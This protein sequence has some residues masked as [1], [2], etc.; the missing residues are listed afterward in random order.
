MTRS[1][2]VSDTDNNSRDGAAA[3][4]A[5]AP[6]TGA[7][8]DGPA[9][10]TSNLTLQVDRYEIFRDVSIQ[11]S[12]GE[13]VGLIGPIGSGK[14]ALLKTLATLTRPTRGGGAVAGQDL[15]SQ[16]DAIRPRVGYM[17][18]V[19]GAYDDLR[20]WEY[21]DF[22]ARA[23]RVEPRHIRSRIDRLLAEAELT[24]QREAFVETLGRE[25]K[26]R[27]GL[28]KTLLH[29]PRLLILDSP[30][31]GLPLAARR[32]L[33]ELIDRLLAPDRTLLL[34]TNIL[35]DLVGLC[36][37]AYVIA[38]GRIVLEGPMADVLRRLAPARAFEVRIGAETDSPERR[39]RLAEQAR[40]TLR[41][42]PGVDQAQ[43]LADHVV[44]STREPLEDP[45]P[46]LAALRAREIPVGGWREREIDLSV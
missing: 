29:E 6:G 9:I 35:S 39:A 20:V 46:W 36:S 45:A 22:F 42:A 10:V 34:G 12:S 37:R 25:E 4:A 2:S 24:D 5:P 16:A 30:A 43:S 19:L 33:R 11:V 32:R 18:D 28:I 15:L 40:E 17:P 23:G 8:P 13:R 44:F 26:R 41:A 38:G 31:A 3:A 21:L 1:T 27:L 7:F 14:S